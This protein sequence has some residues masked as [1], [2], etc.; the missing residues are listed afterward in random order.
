MKIRAKNMHNDNEKLSKL[1]L[2][3]GDI[4]IPIY[5]FKDKWM[6]MVL[7]LVCVPNC[8]T[9]GQIAHLYLD[10]VEEQGGMSLRDTKKLCLMHPSKGF[11]FN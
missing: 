4:G 9:L 7:K 2:H 5:G 10:L 11:L 3:M 8:R 1:A 6:D